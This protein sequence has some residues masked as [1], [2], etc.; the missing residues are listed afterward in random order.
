MSTDYIYIALFLLAAILFVVTTLLIPVTLRF[1]KIIPHN[2]TPVKGSPFECGVETIG[3]TWVQ[4]N[5]R[6]YLYALVFL[7]I[8]V[9]VVFLYP[10]AVNIRHLGLTGLIEMLILLTIVTVG[11][12]YAWKKGAL[13]WK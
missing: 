7:I 5:L 9:L 6:Y 12:I 10:W 13:E 2:P 3:K 8:D 1:L 4:F 11:Y